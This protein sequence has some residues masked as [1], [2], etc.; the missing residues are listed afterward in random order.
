MSETTTP[1]PQ[2][3]IQQMVQYAAAAALAVSVLALVVLGKVDVS[4]YLS[5][6]VMPGLTA[7]GIHTAAKNLN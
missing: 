2:M 7:L 1:N 5:M 6:I 3:G 4:V